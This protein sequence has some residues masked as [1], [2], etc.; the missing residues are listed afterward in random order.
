MAGA[1]AFPPDSTIHIIESSKPM[2][3]LA[4]AHTP[5]EERIRRIVEGHVAI[6]DEHAPRVR[7]TGLKQRRRPIEVRQDVGEHARR[8]GRIDL[9]IVQHTHQLLDA[10][11]LVNLPMALIQRQTKGQRIGMVHRSP[12]RRIRVLLPDVP[13]GPIADI[14]A[15]LR[16]DEAGAMVAE[17]AD[18]LLEKLLDQGSLRK[19]LL[20]LEEPRLTIG[21]GQQPS[22]ST[23]END[24]DKPNE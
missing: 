7:G 17:A 24:T 23:Q 10:R 16:G 5:D 14:F 1:P 11:Q 4:T 12:V 18:C 13:R 2:S 9:R 20:L 3:I 15:V 6:E 8:Q 19:R 22:R 21:G